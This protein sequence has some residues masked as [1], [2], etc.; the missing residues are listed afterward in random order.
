M[1][2]IFFLILLLMSIFGFSQSPLNSYNK[3]IIPSKFSFQKQD[4]EYRINSTIK[5]FLIEKGFEAYLSNETMPK[6][7]LDYNCNKIYIDVVE[8]NSIFLTKIKIQFKD[9]RDNV[10]FST[11]LASSNEKEYAKAYNITLLESLK[12]F[13]KANY[14]YSGD[15]YLD[16]ENN[17]KKNIEEEREVVSLEKK[18]VRN[19]DSIELM[20]FKVINLLNQQE[21]VL[22][23]TSQ[24]DVFL[25]IYNNKNGVVIYADGNW[26]FESIQDNKIVSEKLKLKL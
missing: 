22:F 21:L 25:S 8:Q 15:S 16:E 12:S 10:L 19:S 5:A 3:A 11:D 9:C 7:F 24:P 13:E 20:A 1:K 14:N 17:K 23:K 18:S 4:N 26:F 6:G 2:K